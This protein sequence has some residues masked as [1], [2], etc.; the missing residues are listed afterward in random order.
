MAAKSLKASYN[1]YV[2]IRSALLNQYVPQ[3]SHFL[4]YIFRFYL[5]VQQII[6]KCIMFVAQLCFLWN[7]KVY[8]DV[9]CVTCDVY[10]W[11]EYVNLEFNI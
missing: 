1:V 11:V 4:S 3:N 10:C 6:T 7:Y 2:Q 8:D 5:Y 9:T